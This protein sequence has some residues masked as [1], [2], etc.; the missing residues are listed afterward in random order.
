MLSLNNFPVM[1]V[2]DVTNKRRRISTSDNETSSKLW[3]CHLGHISRGG[4][5]GV[6]H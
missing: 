3:H 6:S 5:D 4:G 1:N 2:R